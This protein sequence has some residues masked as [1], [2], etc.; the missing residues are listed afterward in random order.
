MYEKIKSAVDDVRELILTTERHI[1]QNPETGFREWKTSKYLSDILEGFGYKLN[2][3]GNIP[4]FYTDLDTGRPGPKVLIFCELDSLICREHPES[5]PE[6][7]AVH[8]CGHNAQCAAFVGIAAALTRPE[9]TEGMSGSVRLCAVPAEETIEI[10][11][12]QGLK[13]EGIIK[14]LGGKTE[15][16][17]RGYLDGVDMAFMVH[18]SNIE[19]NSFLIRNGAI[20]ITAK[21][22]AY[23]G[24]AAHAGGSPQDGVNALYAATAG[25]NAINALRETFT[26]AEL[27]RVHPI[28]T[29]GGDAVNAIPADV[30]LESFVRAL[31]FEGM[32]K[33]N[34]KV[35]RAL[36]G[37][38][39][40]MG[41]ELKLFDSLGAAPLINDKT[42]TALYEEAACSLTP[43]GKF[44]HI[45]SINTGSTDM[46]DVSMIMP[47]IHP[48]VGGATGTGH[49]K[50]YYIK[51]PE[52]AC[53]T[54]AKVQLI[55][56]ALLLDNGAKLAYATLKNKGKHIMTKEKYL[57]L[58]DTLT[59]E[60]DAV[61]YKDENTASVTY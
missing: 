40:S 53:V 8:C 29:K 19:S 10:E 13:K 48:Y 22:I 47:A 17:H 30:R 28:M 60:L 18:T 24:V 55:L 37:A 36:A 25:L 2:F 27:I 34:K 41:A 33:T 12:R 38:A 1:W 31:T 21:A 57:A 4:G 11:F 39:V 26:E 42:L 20:G 59:Q 7:G 56:L 3:A 35:N 14:Y 16:I 15:F 44:T 6:T 23:K 51:D 52:S 58:A 32:Q 43:A 50:D 46:G 61:V 54:S 45:D 49:G 5:D 9:V